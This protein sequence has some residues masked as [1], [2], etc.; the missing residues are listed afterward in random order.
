[1][2][3]QTG[4]AV[5]FSKWGLITPLDDGDKGDDDVPEKSGSPVI[6]KRRVFSDSAVVL[7][8]GP[9]GSHISSVSSLNQSTVQLIASFC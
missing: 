3:A 1:M 4:M 6:K 8:L 2:D 9:A 5:Q 7:N